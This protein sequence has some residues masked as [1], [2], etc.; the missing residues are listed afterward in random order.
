M[1]PTIE[2]A[3]LKVVIA[4]EGAELQSIILK[5]TGKEHLWQGDATFWTR[6][7]PLLFPIVGRLKND[8]MTFKGKEYNMPQHG[9]ARDLHF[10]V[11]KMTD[12]SIVFSCASTPETR[13][14]YP[15][16]WKLDCIYELEG[17][18]LKASA[19]VT[20]TSSSDLMYFSIGFHPGFVL[21][22]DEG[23]AFDDYLLYF[24]KDHSAKRW[25]IEG[26][27]IGNES[28]KNTIYDHQVQLSS[29]LFE[30]DALVFKGLKSDEIIIK[31]SK[32]D[33]RLHFTFHNFPFLGI[34]TKPG[35]PYLCLEP[36]QGIADSI[37]HNGD[38]TGK[39]GILTLDPKNTFQCGYRVGFN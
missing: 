8:T 34:W 5:K 39:E 6:R 37:Y 15:F 38:F 9:F 25:K 7:A 13:Q 16:D 3:F 27:L 24:N 22:T 32:T 35:A 28:S 19:S 14:K 36:W 10:S 11:E 33:S 30:T 1:H 4:E 26:A 2:N 12:Q 17:D 31:N 21:P 29:S 20:N 18:M 23:L